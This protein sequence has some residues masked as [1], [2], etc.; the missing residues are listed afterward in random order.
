MLK[1][2]YYVEYSDIGNNDI[3]TLLEEMKYF[4]KQNNSNGV[5]FKTERK[6]IKDGCAEYLENRM[7]KIVNVGIEE[8]DFQIVSLSNPEVYLTVDIDIINKIVL[9][10]EEREIIFEIR[11]DED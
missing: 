7:D 1:K 9:N 11:G 8:W 5:S 10:G 2:V 4:I 6:I 3:E